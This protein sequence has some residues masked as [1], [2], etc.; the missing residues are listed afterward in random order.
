MSW[1]RRHMGQTGA[2][3]GFSMSWGQP[4]VPYGGTRRVFHVLGAT[5]CPIWGHQGGP[6]C[7]GDA[8]MSHMGTLGGSPM[9]WGQHHI[10]T[11]RGTWGVLHALGTFPH[12]IWGHMGGPSCLRDPLMSPRPIWGHMG[13]PPCLR[14]PLM[15]PRPVWGTRGSSTGS[16]RRPIGTM[17]SCGDAR[18]RARRGRLG[19]SAPPPPINF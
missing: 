12:P 5:P 17:R 16:P 19:V 1:G 10:G 8:L 14:D 18:T 15:S 11:E 6:P 7:P 9:S 4:H 3:G 2:P 13:G